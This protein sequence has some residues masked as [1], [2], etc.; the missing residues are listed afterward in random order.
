MT[1]PAVEPAVDAALQALESAREMPVEE[2]V[3]ALEDVH[4]AL[5]EALDAP[6]DAADSASA[7]G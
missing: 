3:G 6:D 1:T 7:G 2:R 4:R 5:A